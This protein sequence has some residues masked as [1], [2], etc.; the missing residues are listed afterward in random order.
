MRHEGFAIVLTDVAVRDIARLASEVARELSAIVVLHDDGVLGR[1]K[2]VQNGF[3]VQRNEPSDLEL[4]CG[5]AL[6]I[7]DFYSF[8]NDTLCGTPA[9]QGDI[10]SWCA[11]ERRQF[12]GCFNATD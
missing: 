5:D 8:A 6:F 12:D 7:Q 2:D 11:D 3:S 9:D 4:I 1:L 10:C